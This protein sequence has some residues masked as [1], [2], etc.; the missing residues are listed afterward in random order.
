MAEVDKQKMGPGLSRRED[1]GGQT[2]GERE[3]EKM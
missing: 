3:E 2:P 1:G